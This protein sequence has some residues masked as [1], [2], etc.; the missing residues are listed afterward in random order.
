LINKYRST[1]VPISSEKFKGLS[2]PKVDEFFMLV[3]LPENKVGYMD[4]KAYS[5][6]VNQKQKKAT[7]KI[8]ISDTK[9]VGLDDLKKIM[10]S[11]S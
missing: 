1:V 10:S 9:V 5:K 6:I 3:V 11:F 4:S 8:K 7:I 2:L